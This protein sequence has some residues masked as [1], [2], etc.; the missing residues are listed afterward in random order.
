[1]TVPERLVQVGAEAVK[2]EMLKLVPNETWLAEGRCEE[3]AEAVIAAVLRELPD[4]AKALR[5]RTLLERIQLLALEANEEYESSCRHKV[6]R[7]YE[8]AKEGISE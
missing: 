7:I 2:A 8:L 6:D 1:M 4:E 5:L 3:Y